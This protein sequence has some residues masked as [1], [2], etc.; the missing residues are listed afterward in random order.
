MK[1]TKE[2]DGEGKVS[3]FGKAENRDDLILFGAG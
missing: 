3:L 1:K 2:S